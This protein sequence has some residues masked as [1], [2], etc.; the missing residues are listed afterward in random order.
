MNKNVQKPISKTPV[1]YLFNEKNKSPFINPFRK[2]T[3]LP[4]GR[5][6]INHNKN[7]QLR[8]L[9]EKIIMNFSQKHSNSSESNNSSLI[10]YSAISNLNIRTIKLKKHAEQEEEIKKIISGENNKFNSIQPGIK[11]SSTYIE[12]AENKY[13]I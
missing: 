2:P 9:R 11:D 6:L 12:N 5:P 7:K 8:K 13:V 3:R 4:L 10:N 1:N